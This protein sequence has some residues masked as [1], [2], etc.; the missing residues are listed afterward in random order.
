MTGAAYALAGLAV[1]LRGPAPGSRAYALAL[2]MLGVG[3]MLY[4][5]TRQG[6]AQ[7]L[8][9]FGMYLTFLTFAAVALLPSSP[10]AAVAFVAAYTLAGLLALVVV[11]RTETGMG[12]G[13]ALAVLLL[14]ILGAWS[15]ALV[16][17]ALF[18]AGYWCWHRPWGHPW[19][20]VLT[21]AGFVT[22]WL[23]VTA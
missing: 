2:L 22:L 16:T 5:A 19:W 12:V 3:T 6:W 10:W 8:D 20:H 11:P 15:W 23:G 9:R 1:V 17:V 18:A 21:A 7:R 4:H 14:L 13:F